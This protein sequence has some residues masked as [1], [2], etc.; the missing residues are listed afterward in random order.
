MELTDAH[1]S[2]SVMIIILYIS[3]FTNAL[4]AV[5]GFRD[6]LSPVRRF[7]FFLVSHCSL[8]PLVGAIV[9]ILLVG[10]VI[11]S[12]GATYAV[13]VNSHHGWIMRLQIVPIPITRLPRFPLLEFS[14][15]SSGKPRYQRLR[16]IISI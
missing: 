4:T 11:P 9:T 16:I 12:M 15:I 5:R 7:S 13:Q 10:P 14:I 3:S 2:P 1:A 6:T 8:N